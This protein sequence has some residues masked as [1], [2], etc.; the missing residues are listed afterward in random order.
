[1]IEARD[2]KGPKGILY[3]SPFLFITKPIPPIRAPIKLLEKRIKGTAFHPSH[4]PAIA[5]SL[6]SPPPIPS[7]PVNHLYPIATM[8]KKP[9]PIKIPKRDSTHDISGI[10]K[11]APIPK[12]IPGI[13]I[14]GGLH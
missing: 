13:D 8:N 7:R 11:E 9:P 10:R 5:R 4:A 12:N 3:F 1:M 14:Q 6:I 2:R